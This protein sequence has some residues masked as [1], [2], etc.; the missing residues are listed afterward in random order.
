MKQ[1]VNF[2]VGAVLCAII[3]ACGGDYYYDSSYTVTPGGGTSG[4][5]PKV[6]SFNVSPTTIAS[7]STVTFSWDAYS[8]N[9]QILVNT[10]D[11]TAGA[12]VVA[13]KNSLNGTTSDSVTCT[14]S[15]IYLD[16]GAANLRGNPA[17]I[18]GLVGIFPVYAIVQ[19]SGFNADLSQTLYD[20]RSTK[21]F[22]L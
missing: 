3:S 18:G 6:N 19:A 20:I 4:S 9:T 14:R 2:A 13:S 7:W 1:T 21:V 12:T 16:C 11:S 17:N 15:D 10:I 5:A 22:F 8:I